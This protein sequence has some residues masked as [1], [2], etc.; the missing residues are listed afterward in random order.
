MS[1]S[2]TTTVPPTLAERIVAGTEPAITFAEAARHHALQRNGRPA[3]LCVMY[4]YADKGIRGVRLES[5]RVGGRRVTTA[6]AVGRFVR[7]QN[8]PAS[9]RRQPD[10]VEREL[11]TPRAAAVTSRRAHVNAVSELRAAGLI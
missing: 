5:A 8:E 11:V 4:R 9:D 7:R 1:E 3:P 2:T 6:D 10:R